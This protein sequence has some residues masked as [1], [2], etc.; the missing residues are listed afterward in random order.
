MT[1]NNQRGSKKIAETSPWAQ[2][3]LWL[4]VIAQILTI[5]ITWP[6]WQVRANPPA[7]PRWDVLDWPLP[8]GW[9]MI[10]SAVLVGVLSHRRWWSPVRLSS[11]QGVDRVR[12]DDVIHTEMTTRWRLSGLW[13]H[14]GVY[15]LACGVD[16]MRTQ[17]QLA[18]LWVLMLAVSS[19]QFQFIG[20]WF[21]ISMWLWAGV[22]KLGS[23]EWLGPTS[24]QL[25][26]RS[27]LDPDRWHEWFAYGAAWGEIGVALIA[28]LRPRWAAIGCVALHGGIILFLSPWGIGWN[29]SVIP[30]NVA[31]GIIGGWLFLQSHPLYLRLWVERWVVVVLLIYPVG[32]YFS[33]VDHGI[34]FVLYSENIPKGLVTSSS[35][36]REIVG[37]GALNVP[38]PNERRLLRQHFERTAAAGDKLHLFDPRWALDDRWYRMDDQGRA[39][40]ISRLEFLQGQPIANRL[41]GQT[42]IDGPFRG[43]FFDDP[44]VVWELRRANV[45][46][47]KRSPEEMVYAVAIAPENYQSKLLR[48]IARLQNL[49]QLQLAGTAVT[50]QDLALLRNH[51]C[52]RGIGLAG[53]A[54]TDA[55]LN[56]LATLA[57]LKEIEF[58]NTALTKE[59]VWELLD[60]KLPEP[61][62]Q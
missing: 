6:L 51:D 57:E 42:A 23:S 10:G 15:L 43:Q 37:W 4:A 61:G 33:W 45:R 56:H 30:W 17:P 39:I 19:S 31:S 36:V 38:F 40:E 24:Y 62:P 53:T 28:L 22:H 11:P 60:Q 58:E 32:F 49:E 34:G 8:F 5:W 27:P 26:E 54:V 46:M 52:L 18:A 12:D 3:L 7:L 1:G 2:R 41:R 59:R 55:C 14:L 48:I 47:L 21:L 44:L 20:R 29:Y 25:L 13:I 16:Q 9:L 50:D 35:G